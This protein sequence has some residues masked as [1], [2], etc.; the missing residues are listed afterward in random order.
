M[1]DRVKQLK[2]TYPPG[3]RLEL[4]HV[5]NRSFRSIG[6]RV[7]GIIHVQQL[8]PSAGWI[9]FFVSFDSVCHCVTSI[10]N[11]SFGDQSMSNSDSPRSWHRDSRKSGRSCLRIVI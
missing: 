11:S 6:N 2:E 9:V 5:F 8:Q 7:V 3:T 4:L 1:T 10:L